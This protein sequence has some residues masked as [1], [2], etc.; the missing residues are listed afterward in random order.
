MDSE[1][2]KNDDEVAAI[3]AREFALNVGY[4]GMITHSEIAAAF[5]I[6]LPQID[7][8]SADEIKK[9]FEMVQFKTLAMVERL[10]EHMLETHKMH[11]ESNR[12]NGYLIVM[13]SDQGRLAFE[14]MKKSVGAD[15]RKAINVLQNVNNS[16]LTDEQVKSNDE[17][18]GKIA[19]LQAFSTKRIA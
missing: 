2:I 1:L 7:G 13:P 4:G 18:L 10:K 9:A 16:L 8:K 3:V 19:A 6:Q 12:G 17:R 14:R 5:Q 15:I 11:M